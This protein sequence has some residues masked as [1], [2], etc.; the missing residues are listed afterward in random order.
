MAT[1]IIVSPLTEALYGRNI[2]IDGQPLQIN[3]NVAFNQDIT[4]VFGRLLDRLLLENEHLRDGEEFE[5]NTNDELYDTIRNNVLACKMFASRSIGRCYITNKNYGNNC[6]ELKAHVF[7]GAERALGSRWFYSAFPFHESAKHLLP[8]ADLCFNFGEYMVPILDFQNI[9][10]HSDG[11][12]FIVVNIMRTRGLIHTGII[13]IDTKAMVVYRSIEEKVFVHPAYSPDHLNIEP[14]VTTYF[15]YCGTDIDLSKLDEN[16]YPI[17]DCTKDIPINT[18]IKHN[19]TLADAFRIGEDS[20]PT[21][22]TAFEV[23][24]MNVYKRQ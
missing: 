16:G 24:A 21:F 14:I 6:K 5:P 3:K 11:K 7:T 22:H 10:K 1:N 4:D 18:L 12:N 15:N 2:E 13:K 23:S 9:P 8:F 19:P 17:T 20:I